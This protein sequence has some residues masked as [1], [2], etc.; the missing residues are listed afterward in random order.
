M[1]GGNFGQNKNNGHETGEIFD[2]SYKWCTFKAICVTN[3]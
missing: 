3:G 1:G 2:I